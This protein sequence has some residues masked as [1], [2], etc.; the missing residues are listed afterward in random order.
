ME[1]WNNKLEELGFQ[2]VDAIISEQLR[3]MLNLQ[4][5][6][7]DFVIKFIKE[8]GKNA[9]LIAASEKDAFIFTFDD[10][11]LFPSW[12]RIVDMSGRIK[13]A[14]EPVSKIPKSPNYWL[15]SL[16]RNTVNPF[17]TSKRMAKR[18]TTMPSI[19]AKK[20]PKNEDDKQ[21]KDVVGLEQND[22]NKGTKR[23]KSRKMKGKKRE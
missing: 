5:F 11:T 16:F 3:L 15:C 19:I 4:S 6:N 17:Y 7:V 14:V 20:K 12:N 1:E 9:K 8:F 2:N 22:D 23:D 13:V 21:E 10:T 18:Q